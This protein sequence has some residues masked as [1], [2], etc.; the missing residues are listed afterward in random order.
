LEALIAD[1]AGNE[2]VSIETGPEIGLSAGLDRFGDEFWKSALL[3]LTV[4]LRFT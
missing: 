4:T 2:S 3:A 1:R